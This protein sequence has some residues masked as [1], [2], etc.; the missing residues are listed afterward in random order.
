MSFTVA[1]LYQ[2]TRLAD[3]AQMRQTLEDACAKRNLIGL[4]LVAQEGINGTL[5]GMREDLD[6]FRDFLLAEGSFSPDR[7]SWKYSTASLRPFRDLRVR[8]KPEIVTLRVPDLDPS[9]HV[10]T[11]VKPKDWNALI[12]QP[13]VVLVDTRNDYEV[14]I[15]TFENAVDPKTENFSQFPQWVTQNLDPQK[16][17]KVAMFCTGGIRCEKSTSLLLKQGFKEVYHLQG[18]I[19]QYLEEVPKEESK[20]RGECF[21]FDTRAAVGHGLVE[22]DAKICFHCGHP[23]TREEQALPEWD[24]RRKCANC[25]AGDATPSP[26]SAKRAAR[27]RAKS[28]AKRAAKRTEK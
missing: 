27:R 22:G 15:G 19:L 20:W 26:R 3:P 9:A 28:A 11:Y 6:S 16:H 1:A 4:L 24:R 8:L 14:R 10:G 17:P 18:G 2:F 23:V 13:D 21:V 7:L 25:A 5:A 12:S